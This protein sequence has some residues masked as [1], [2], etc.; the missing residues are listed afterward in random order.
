MGDSTNLPNR[1]VSDR[2]KVTSFMKIEHIVNDLSTFIKENSF[3]L[4]DD[5][6]L[7]SFLEIKCGGDYY[8][9]TLEAEAIRY[10][11]SLDKLKVFLTEEEYA[12]FDEGNPYEKETL[13]YSVVSFLSY[14]KYAWGMAESRHSLSAN[15]SI[16]KLGAWLFAFGRDDLYALIHDDTLYNPYGAPALI[17]VCDNLGISV[18][19]SL[20][21]FSKQKTE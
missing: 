9:G 19:V 21:E 4:K 17:A 7:F 3:V 8:W 18:P 10:L 1:Y 13:E 5:A 6:E 15:R 20:I 11:L 12:D 14:M 2:Q 16:A